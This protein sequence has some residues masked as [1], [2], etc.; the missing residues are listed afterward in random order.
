MSARG[1]VTRSGS[2]MV[3]LLLAALQAQAQTGRDVSVGYSSIA[4][5]GSDF[6]IGV[7]VSFA[8][9]QGVMKGVGDI[10]VQRSPGG[11]GVGLFLAGV[12][13]APR[14]SALVTPFGQALFGFAA[15]GRSQVF[16]AWA[17]QVGGGVD[18]GSRPTGPALRLGLDLPLLFNGDGQEQLIRATVGVVH[19]W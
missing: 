15:G 4:I 6:P 8:E 11:G 17:L 14:R 18:I 3:L 19:R 16:G 5:G 9:G 2:M 7:N 12:R 10:T 13:L 1:V